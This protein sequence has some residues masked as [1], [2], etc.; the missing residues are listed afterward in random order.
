M[1]VYDNKK[2]IKKNIKDYFNK[3]KLKEQIEEKN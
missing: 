3:K 1:H 2:I